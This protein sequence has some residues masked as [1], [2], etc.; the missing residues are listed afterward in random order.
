LEKLRTSDLWQR[1]PTTFDLEPFYKKH[2]NMWAASNKIK[3]KTTDSQDFK[4]KKGS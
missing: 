2:D 4:L 3:Y 1:G